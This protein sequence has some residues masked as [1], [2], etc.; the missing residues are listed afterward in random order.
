V[1]YQALL[2]LIIFGGWLGWKLAQHRW[3]RLLLW[4]SWGVV[5]SAA[6]IEFW[7]ENFH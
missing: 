3:V 2:A 5:I 6:T 7:W 4:F 1:Q